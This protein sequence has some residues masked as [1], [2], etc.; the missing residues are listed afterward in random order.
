MESN[1]SELNT[2][3]EVDDRGNVVD[4][5]EKQDDGTWDKAARLN[6]EAGPAANEYSWECWGSSKMEEWARQNGYNDEISEG[7]KEN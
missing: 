6:R 5:F 3:F 1:I 7:Q 2:S 4:F